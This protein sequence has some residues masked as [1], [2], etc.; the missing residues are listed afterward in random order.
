MRYLLSISSLFK[1][2]NNYY[3]HSHYNR[4]KLEVIVYFISGLGLYLIIHLIAVCIA[5][6]ENTM[7]EYHFIQDLPQL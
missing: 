4:A 5:K 2:L 1:V 7:F 6:E 3:F